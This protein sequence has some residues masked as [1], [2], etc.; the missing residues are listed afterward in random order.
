MKQKHP[1]KSNRQQKLAAV[2]PMEVDYTKGEGIA[3]MHVCGD[4]HP[5][6]RGYK[7]IRAQL[8]GTDLTL[9]LKPFFEP[10][11]KMAQEVF[12]VP[13]F[14]PGQIFDWSINTWSEPV[15]IYQ[16]DNNLE[17]LPTIKVEETTCG[18]TD[19]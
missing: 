13:E 2:L 12:G 14:V 15:E 10:T 11:I 1:A 7:I 4:L 5:L 8:V 16:I 6:P 3:H 17:R 19:G 9:I 18:K